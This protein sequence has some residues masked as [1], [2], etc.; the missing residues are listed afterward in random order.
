MSEIVVRRKLKHRVKIWCE[1]LPPQTEIEGVLRVAR[2]VLVITLFDDV[3]EC[4]TIAAPEPEIERKSD[5]I[6][7]RKDRVKIQRKL[8]QALSEG[9]PGIIEIYASDK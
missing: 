9:E 7:A 5:V 4:V 1:A 3:I 8:I 6:N 2:K